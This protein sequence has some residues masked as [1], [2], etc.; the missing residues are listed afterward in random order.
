[1]SK[2]DF[3]LVLLFFSTLGTLLVAAIAIWGNLFKSILV[4]PKLKIVGQN[5]KGELTLIGDSNFRN[6]VIYYHLKVINDRNWSTAK[7]CKVLLTEVHLRLPNGQ[8]QKISLNSYP[9]FRW[10]PAEITGI[11]IDISHEQIFDFGRIIENGDRFEPILSIYPNNFNG[12]VSSN[13]VVRYTLKIVAEGYVSKKSQ[14][15][16]VAWNGNWSEN[17]EIMA[18][19]LT[20]REIN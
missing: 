5:L 15:F 12:F 9:S 17:I 13:N 20:I 18:Q 1:M 7:N 11:T 6:K 16:E 8:F 19:N 2:I 4:P 3:N 14:V 10:T